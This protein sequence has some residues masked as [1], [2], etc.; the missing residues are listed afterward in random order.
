[1]KEK[2]KGRGRKE[3]EGGKKEEIKEK[4]NKEERRG[5][6]GNWDHEKRDEGKGVRNLLGG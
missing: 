3:R 6:K 5:K 1:M 4:R 2:S